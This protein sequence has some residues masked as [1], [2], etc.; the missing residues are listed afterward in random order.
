MSRE[1]LRPFRKS[2]QRA[3]DLGRKGG[4]ANKNNPKTIFSAKLRELKKRQSMSNTDL[5]WFVECLENPSANMM[6]IA[7]YLD[8]HK[9]DI[10]PEKY[11]ALRD[12]LHRSI[13][14]DKVNINQKI[15]N[16]NME[17]SNEETSELLELLN[18]NK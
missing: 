3:K 2:E 9:D 6:D 8:E 12:R 15:V 11:V 18:Q 10:D 14:G 5:A 7:K 13:F 16:I 4:L 1:D 17:L